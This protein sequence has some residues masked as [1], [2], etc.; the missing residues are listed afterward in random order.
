MKRAHSTGFTDNEIN[1]VYSGLRPGEKLYEELLGADESSLQTPH[2]KLRIAR[3][4]QENGAW[5]S[6]LLERLRVPGHRTDAEVRAELAN[7]VP[8]YRND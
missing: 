7:W 2:P 6:Q 5:L 8:E 4:R 1:I 3:A